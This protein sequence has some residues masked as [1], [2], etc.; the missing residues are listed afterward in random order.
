[1]LRTVLRDDELTPR[2]GLGG[3]VNCGLH[4]ILAAAE[5]YEKVP[6]TGNR[7]DVLLVRQTV[8]SNDK[9]AELSVKGEGII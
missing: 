2:S 9:Q 8:G 5:G 6:V 3:C 1:M 4:N 7:R